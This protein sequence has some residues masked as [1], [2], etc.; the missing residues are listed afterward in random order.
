MLLDSGETSLNDLVPWCH[1]SQRG[2]PFWACHPLQCSALQGT[3]CAGRSPGSA[4]VAAT[5][6]RCGFRWPLSSVSLSLHACGTWTVP[7]PRWP[8]AW[9]DKPAQQHPPASRGGRWPGLDLALAGGPEGRRDAELCRLPPGP[10]CSEPR[11]VSPRPA[12]PSSAVP[13]SSVRSLSMERQDVQGAPHLDDR[14]GAPAAPGLP[15]GTREQRAEGD[16]LC[17]AAWL[18]VPRSEA[19]AQGG[20]GALR[21]HTPQ[22]WDSGSPA[23]DGESAVQQP[24]AGAVGRAGGGPV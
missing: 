4:T 13:A 24:R 3:R 21:N 22:T 5:R 23:D 15:P 12:V 7:P 14:P 19:C 20:L 11:A 10:A 2:P 9:S 6:Q 16:V 18:A 17:W 8:L 1:P